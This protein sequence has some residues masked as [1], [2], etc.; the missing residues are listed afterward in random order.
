MDVATPSDRRGRRD[1]PT[2]A[3]VVVVGAGIVGLA[4]AVAF[5]RRHP[6]MI[7]LVLDKEPGPARHQSG[8]N[9]GVVHSGLYYTPGSAKA[10]LVADGRERLRRHC[11]R[12]GVPIDWCGKVVVATRATELTALDDLARRGTANGV[13]VRRVGPRGLHDLEPHVSG[14]A[15]LHVPAAGIVD[16]R[17]VARTLVDELTRRGGELRG[18]AEVVRITAPPGGR[19]VRLG[20]RDGS[21]V[22]ARWLVNCAGLHSD[23]IARLAGARTGV[24]IVPFRG[25]YHELVPGAQHLV[26]NLVYPVPDPRWPFLGVHF[27]R[28]VDGH[29]HVGPNAV[30]AL[31]R[32]AYRGGAVARDVREL[33]M[34][35][36]LRTLARTYWRTG[37]HELVRSRTPRLL[38]RDVR[39]LVPEVVASDLVPAAAGIRAQ[40]LGPDGRLLDDFAFASSDRAVHVVNAPSPAATA[41]FAIA[42]VVADRVDALLLDR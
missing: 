38:L 42:E 26:R 14:L 31:G 37:A 25:E 10:G 24:S 21:G 28:T 41:S 13:E 22:G 1:R 3:D 17:E 20:L 33:A 30:L 7:V 27:T 35:R 29:V 40:A 19:A 6:G 4:S 36:P 12:W 34:H 16:Y 32:E 8:R 23:R 2:D 11:E 5:Q 39:R 18:D 9:S 15:A